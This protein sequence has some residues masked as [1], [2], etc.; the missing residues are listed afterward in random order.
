MA[1][2]LFTA[3]NSK[4]DNNNGDD[5]QTQVENGAIF[6]DLPHI[7][8]EGHEAFMKLKEETQ[9]NK[10]FDE[11]TFM[12]YNERYK[13]LVQET[14]KKAKKEALKLKGRVVPIHGENFYDFM[15]ITQAVIDT[16]TFNE[17]DCQA[18]IKI[19]FVTTDEYDPK[20]VSRHQF[21]Y[22]LFVSNDSKEIM[23]NATM[24][25]YPGTTVSLGINGKHSPERWSEFKHIEFLPEDF[26][27]QLFR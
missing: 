17:K 7:M 23:R 20:N 11:A 21:V 19:K 8:A 10:K 13:D 26:A 9:Q 3:C 6:G 16:V 2:L 25:N 24:G 1:L 4:Q 27:K 14:V 12:K 15:H 18:N 5:Q 22:F